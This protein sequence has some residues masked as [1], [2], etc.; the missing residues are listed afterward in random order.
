MGWLTWGPV[1]RISML[2]VDIPWIVIAKGYQWLREQE[3][4]SDG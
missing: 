4:S 2:L 1:L 3:G